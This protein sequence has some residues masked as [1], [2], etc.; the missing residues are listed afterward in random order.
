MLLKFWFFFSQKFLTDWVQF[1]HSVNS[2]SLWP[3]ELQHARLSCPSP[4]PVSYSNSWPSSLMPFNHL[5][6]CHPLLYLLQSSQASGSFPKS[7]FFATGGQSIGVS[8]SASVLPMNIQ[9]WLHL[10]WTGWNLLLSKGLSRVFSNTTVQKHH[11]FGAQ[12][13]L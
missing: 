11:F 3:H 8:A 12:P 5:F 4:T 7:L 10:G 9:H 2:Y 13:S 1:S 6:L